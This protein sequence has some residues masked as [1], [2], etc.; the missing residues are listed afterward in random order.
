MFKIGSKVRYW[1]QPVDA[2]LTFVVAAHNDDGTVELSGNTGAVHRVP[3]AR[4]VRVSS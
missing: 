4:L 1:S 2:A 3:V